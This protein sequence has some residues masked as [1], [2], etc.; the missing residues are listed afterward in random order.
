MPVQN[1]LKASL[2]FVRQDRV[3]DQSIVVALTCAHCQ[4][5]VTMAESADW[6]DVSDQLLSKIFDLQHNA[7]DNCAAA[8]T[9]ASWRC[10][11]NTSHISFLHLHAGHSFSYK[12]WSNFLL[13]K[14]SVG[15]LRLTASVDFACNRNHDLDWAQTFMQQ[16]ALICDHLDA[17]EPFATELP[18]LALQPAQ[19][20]KLTVSL[21]FQNFTP[22][23]CTLPDIRHF[24]QLTALHIRLKGNG[25]WSDAP[26]VDIRTLSRLPES[27]DYLT[28]QGYHWRTIPPN[29]QPLIQPC[30][31]SMQTL[32]LKECRVAFDGNT[33]TCLCKLSSF[34]AASSEIW[35]G[36]N[37]LEQLTKLTCLDLAR[38][39]WRRLNARTGRPSPLL[40]QPFASFTGWPELKVFKAAG[41]NLFHP[42]TKLDL[43]G[44]QDI[45]VGFIVP[46]LVSTRLHLCHNQYAKWALGPQCLLHPS[47]KLHLDLDNGC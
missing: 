8:C 33:I 46:K 3:C 18:Y 38:S 28:I 10:A 16:I 4:A 36:V 37:N 31:A 21:L 19:L 25:F 40:L 34:S 13:S 43:P 20:K 6:S 9:C 14:L 26:H 5:Q 1:M 2:P 42:S 45:Q 39:T 17:D 7:L 12:H 41:C 22:S 27:L 15:S 35:A 29:L 30:L 32:T 47:C 23:C 24:T 11:F 44:V